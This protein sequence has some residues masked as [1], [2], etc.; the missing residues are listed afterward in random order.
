MPTR[1][2]HE[3]RLDLPTQLSGAFGNR[4]VRPGDTFGISSWSPDHLVV[5]WG[6]ATTPASKK[7][8]IFAAT[9]TVSLL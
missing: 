3:A 6:S 2:P 4:G 5:S 8:E 7:S 1:V 9:V